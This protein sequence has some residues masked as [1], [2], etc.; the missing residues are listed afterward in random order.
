MYMNDFPDEAMYRP[1][2]V[3]EILSTN[4]GKTNTIP[5]CEELMFY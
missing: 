1:K 5:Q 2:H 3:T 4:V